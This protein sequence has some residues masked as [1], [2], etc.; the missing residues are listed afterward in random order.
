MKLEPKSTR[1]AARERAET[2]EFCATDLE[3][4]IE[5]KK[6]RSRSRSYC[7]LHQDFKSK[8]SCD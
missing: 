1:L 5:T 3:M 6:R 4:W 7:D 8:C 2:F